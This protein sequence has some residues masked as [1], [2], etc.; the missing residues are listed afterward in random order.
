MIEFYT[1]EDVI[2][3]EWHGIDLS[4]NKWY[5]NRHWS[6]RNKEKEF[7]A[8]TF[9]RLLP[10]RTRQID[11]YMITLKF[12]SRLDASNTVPMIKILEDTM[13]KE[14]YIVDDSRKYCKGIMIYPDDELGKKHY[15]L[16]IH[17][18]SYVKKVK[19]NSTDDVPSKAMRPVRR[20]NGS[21]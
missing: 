21:K 13:K 19:T 12:N 17:I 7:W 14:H 6:F 4:L 20:R 2:D 15:K 18:L 11:K 8:T 9:I 5:A 16:T 3:I 10:K 1:V